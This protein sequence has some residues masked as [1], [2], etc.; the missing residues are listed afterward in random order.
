[1]CCDLLWACLCARTCRLAIATGGATFV[2]STPISGAGLSAHFGAVV[3][4]SAD[5]STLVVSDSSQLQLFNRSDA[6]PD[7]WSLVA[8]SALPSGLPNTTSTTASQPCLLLTESHVVY[9][10]PIAGKLSV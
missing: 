8:T 9:S 1:M 7:V 5:G 4:V 2:A 10:D 6:T 3:A